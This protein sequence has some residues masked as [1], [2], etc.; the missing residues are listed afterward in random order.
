MS[1]AN[2]FPQLIQQ[3]PRFDGQFEAFELKA[4]DC[5]V[6]LSSYPGGTVVPPHSHET[7]NVGVI[8]RGTLLLTMSG[9]TKT[10][11]AGEWYHVPQGEEHAAEFPEDTAGIEFWFRVP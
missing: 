9:E 5:D 2:Y 8:T 4:Q 7:E 1:L 3:L 6:L 10:I 11:A